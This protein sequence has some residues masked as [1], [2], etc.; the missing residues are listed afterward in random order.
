MCVCARSISG[1]F[2]FGQFLTCA[3]ASQNPRFFSK[4]SVLNVK[5]EGWPESLQY[6]GKPATLRRADFLAAIVYR[7]GRQVLILVR[8]VRLSLAVP[9]T[10]T[11]ESTRLVLRSRPKVTRAKC[12]HKTKTGWPCIRQPVNVSRTR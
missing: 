12:L 6:H 10:D 9:I 2:R 7:L 1:F 4:N 11:G 3:K 8:G 5:M